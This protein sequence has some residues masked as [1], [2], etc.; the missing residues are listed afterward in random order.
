MTFGV[1]TD[2]AGAAAQLERFVEAGG[3]LIDTAEVHG[4]GRSEETV[5]R[6]V[7]NRGGHDDLVIATKDRFPMVDGWMASSG[8]A[9][10]ATSGCPTTPAASS[11]RCRGRRAAVD[12]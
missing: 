11:G 1:E 8:R 3:T 6:W 4:A 9:R 10:S 2:E 12:G 5:G 7:S